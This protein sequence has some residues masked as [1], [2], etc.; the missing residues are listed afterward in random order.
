VLEFDC[1]VYQSEQGVVPA[2]ADVV[3]G[4]NS[5]STL[6]QDYRPGSHEFGIVS[7][8]AES[9][10]LAVSPVSGAAA[11]LFVGH[12]GSPFNALL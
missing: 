11:A 5:S 12:T 8:D 1:T 3:A 2:Q 10:S 6:S 7:F 9:L 4:L